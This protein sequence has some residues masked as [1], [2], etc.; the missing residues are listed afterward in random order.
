M[1]AARQ[2]RKSFRGRIVLRTIAGAAIA[3]LCLGPA[4]IGAATTERIVTSPY[5]GLALSGYDPVAYFIDAA[6]KVGRGDLELRFGGYDPVAVVRGVS[7]A[8]HPELWL[9]AEQPLY[10]FYNAAARTAFEHDPERAIETA[11]QRWPE[12]LRA[13]VP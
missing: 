12:L 13:L 2:E 3:V 6:P 1:T 4:P 9:I 7:T 8:G 10:L 11:E 5:S